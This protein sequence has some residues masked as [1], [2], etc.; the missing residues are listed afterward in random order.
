MHGNSCWIV[1]VVWWYMYQII[2]SPSIALAGSTTSKLCKTPKKNNPTSSLPAATRNIIFHRGKNPE[3]KKQ[4]KC[5][6]K[7]RWSSKA[8]V[9][10]RLMRLSK[11]AHWR[12]RLLLAHTIHVFLGCMAQP[13]ADIC[14]IYGITMETVRSNHSFVEDD[15]QRSALC[16]W[17]LWMWAR[18]SLLL[19]VTQIGRNVW[20]NPEL[21]MFDSW[22]G[23]LL[24]EPRAESRASIGSRIPT[25]LV[26][27]T[28]GKYYILINVIFTFFLKKRI[29][30]S[31]CQGLYVMSCIYCI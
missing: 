21:V 31:C 26:S 5:K 10:S 29:I 2:H 28:A 12:K 14:L 4:I 30:S 16:Q 22:T 9:W 24:H 13:M 6:S 11:C 18:F 19:L 23:S 15:S 1:G 8:A 27:E 17:H 7:V 25:C 20:S 3:T